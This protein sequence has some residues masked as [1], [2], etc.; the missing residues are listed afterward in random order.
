[1]FFEAPLP[2]PPLPSFIKF[3]P[4]IW[5]FLARFVWWF[6]GHTEG[7][8]SRAQAEVRAHAVAQRL[9]DA[10]EQGDNVVLLAHGFFNHMVGTA[11]KR[12]GWRQVS[13][14]GHKYWSTRRYERG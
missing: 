6:F 7:Q 4:K 5:G 14:R 11:L 13:G 8:E 9:S 2:P 12:M 1:M 10:A 3:G